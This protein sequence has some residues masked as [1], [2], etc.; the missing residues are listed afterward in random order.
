MSTS[1]YI[2]KLKKNGPISS[3]LNSKYYETERKKI[4]FDKNP[5]SYRVYAN[6]GVRCAL[7]YPYDFL[8]MVNVT[9]KQRENPHFLFLSKASPH[10][11]LKTRTPLINSIK[12][13]SRS[14][15]VISFSPLFLNLRT[16]CIMKCGT[17]HKCCRVAY[18]VTTRK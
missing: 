14:L 6:L 2:N 18:Y 16:V 10:S 11:H 17:M 7:N 15:I 4:E 1:K 5:V 9:S 13:Q 3:S 12:K 8:Q